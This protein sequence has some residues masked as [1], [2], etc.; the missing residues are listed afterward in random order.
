M[1]YIRKLDHLIIRNNLNQNLQ[2]NHMGPKI[3]MWA[4]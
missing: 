4:L 3:L 1:L 2:L